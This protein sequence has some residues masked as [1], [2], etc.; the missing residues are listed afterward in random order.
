[1]NPIAITLIANLPIIAVVL[2]GFVLLSRE[3]SKGKAL[4]LTGL[5]VV[6]A[7]GLLAIPLTLYLWEYHQELMSQSQRPQIILS[8]AFSVVHAIGLLFCILGYRAVSNNA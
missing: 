1:M 4:F 2:V 7:L 8:I 6:L 5:A 3:R